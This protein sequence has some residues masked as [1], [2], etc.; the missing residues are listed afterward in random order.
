[1]SLALW[2]EGFK[3]LFSKLCF[4][5]FILW[6]LLSHISERR[7]WQEGLRDHPSYNLTCWILYNPH[8]FFSF[9]IG[10][11]P[12]TELIPLFKKEQI[13]TKV[14]LR[15]QN[16][17]Y[18]C[19]SSQTRSLSVIF[20][21]LQILSNDEVLWPLPRGHFMGLPAF[22]HAHTLYYLRYF[23]LQRRK[24]QRTFN[25]GAHT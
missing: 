22:V 25:R 12:S 20:E 8:I 10:H 4:L 14:F 16:P 21:W 6:S 15:E 2:R 17:Q 3:Y 23:H 9:G 18:G 24:M 19:A 11:F 13:K 5:W 7:L 1:M